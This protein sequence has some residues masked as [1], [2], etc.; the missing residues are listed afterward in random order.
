MRIRGTQD[1][2]GQEYELFQYIVQTFYRIAKKYDVK[3]LQTSTLVSYDTI[4]R[5]SGAD[6]DIVSKEM[7]FAKYLKDT[8]KTEQEIKI[9]QEVSDEKDDIILK[10]EGTAPAIRALHDMNVHMCTPLR[11]GYLDR[12]FRYCRPQKGRLRE[13]HQVGVEFFGE[14]YLIDLQN[15]CLAVEFLKALKLLD[16]LTLNINTIG[17]VESRAIFSK[18][19]GEYFIQH[20]HLIKHWHNNPLRILDKLT[21]IEKVQMPDMPNIID[22]INEDDR[23]YFDKITDGLDSLGIQ[24][25]INSSIVRGLDYYSH[26]VFEFTTQS[27]TAQNTVLAG[28]RYDNLIKQISQHQDMS[29]IGWGAGIERLM[30]LCQECNVQPVMQTENILLI[31]MGCDMH[32]LQLLHTLQQHLTNPIN[33]ITVN[34]LGKGLDMANKSGYTHVIICGENEMHSQQYTYKH[35]TQHIQRVF[36]IG[37]LVEYIQVLTA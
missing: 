8:T 9:E 32:C 3:F 2:F 1:L 19:L 7:F 17:G 12:M 30:I 33:M 21:D 5:T 34:K 35:M 23:V 18:A 4:V 15:I 25:K 29:A 20:K 11:I 28:G 14:D 13:F 10:P 31:N 24:Y 26:I 27:K 22:F 36:P 6:S 16:H 37:E